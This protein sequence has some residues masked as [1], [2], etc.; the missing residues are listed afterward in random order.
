LPTNYARLRVVCRYFT[1]QPTTSNSPRRWR[2]GR[3]NLFHFDIDTAV[4]AFAVPCE[5]HV[6]LSCASVA[7]ELREETE[8]DTR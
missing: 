5:G 6:P 3:L 4:S 7:H 2:D 1:W 8:H